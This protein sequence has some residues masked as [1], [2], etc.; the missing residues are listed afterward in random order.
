VEIRLDKGF[1][2]ASLIGAERAAALQQQGNAF[3]GRTAPR[4]MLQPG[5]A[6]LLELN[7]VAHDELLSLSP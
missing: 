4:P 6:V 3:E 2:D 7:L 1:I 5:W